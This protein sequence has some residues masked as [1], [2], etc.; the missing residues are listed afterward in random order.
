[1]LRRTHDLMDRISR[2][3]VYASGAM[4]LVVAGLVA[5]EVVARRTIGF[6]ITGIDELSGYAYAIS[7][8]WGFAFTLFQR[9]HIRVDAV[10]VRLPARIC[11]V[12]DV[13]ALLSLAG[14]IS[15]LSLRALFLVR[16]TISLAAVSSSPLQVP[17]WIPQALWLSGLA[18]FV[19]CLW[20]LFLRSFFALLR[21][22]YE[23]IERIAHAPDMSEEIE[24]NIDDLST[25]LSMRG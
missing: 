11:R 6:T 18:F 13:V 24:V 14:L 1:M 17:L 4:L 2:L 12:L 25:D 10:Y 20:F 3:A 23:T 5:F 21:G 15:Y 19:L 9:G 16:Q 22:D 8:A 7:M